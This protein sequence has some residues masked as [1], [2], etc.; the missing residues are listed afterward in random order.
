MKL[1]P[2]YDVIVAVAIPLIGFTGIFVAIVWFYRWYSRNAKQG[3]ENIYI[4]FRP[5][6][7]PATGTVHV[8]YH[9]YSGLIAWFTQTEHSMY[10]Q[11]EQARQFLKHLR[12]YNLKWGL[13]SYGCLFVP[14]L[15]FGNYWDQMRAISKQ[16]KAEETA[17]QPSD[18][19]R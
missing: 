18:R 10:L 2:P 4:Q 3:I 13:L 16:E 6:D 5:S 1:P 15:T 12:N 17:N 19:T 8:K 9:T 14:I 11:P 7:S